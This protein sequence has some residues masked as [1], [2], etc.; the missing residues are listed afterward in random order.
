MSVDYFGKYFNENGFDFTGL[1]NDDFFKPVKLLFKEKHY[2]SASKLLFVAIDSISYIEYGDLK[3]NTFIKW[4]NEYSDIESLKITSEEL[5]E[6]RNSLLHMSSLASRKVSSGKVRSLV[7]YI[8]ELHPEVT[9]DETNTGYYSLYSL[10]MVVAK[11][12]EKWCLT[13]SDKR[14]KIHS[15]VDRYDLIASDARL[16]SIAYE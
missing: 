12:C 13:Y 6:H 14:E 1:I 7:A 9:L 4:L 8:G 16:F 11:A 2:I 10:F 5:W 15:F 3:E